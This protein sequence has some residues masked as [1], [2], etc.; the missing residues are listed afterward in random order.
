MLSFR[1]VT[2]SVFIYSDILNHESIPGEASSEHC[3]FNIGAGQLTL[4]LDKAGL[5]QQNEDRS[6]CQKIK[7]TEAPVGSDSMTCMLGAFTEIFS[8]LFIQ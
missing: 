5:Y 8:F 2:S 4:N 3:W 7:K 6:V 1:V